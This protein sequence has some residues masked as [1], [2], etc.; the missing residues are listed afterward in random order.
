MLKIKAERALRTIPRIQEGWDMHDA[1]NVAPGAVRPKQSGR[2]LRSGAD[3]GMFEAN[4]IPTVPPL[5]VDTYLRR[6]DDAAADAL[7]D[8]QLRAYETSAYPDE[9]A[10]A[11]MWASMSPS[12]RLEAGVSSSYYDWIT[13]PSADALRRR[14]VGLGGNIVEGSDARQA[15]LLSAIIDELG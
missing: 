10:E 8:A 11:E 2:M 1:V 15:A 4:V 5:D 3:A 6:L 14:T 12:D 13:E 7:D 9:V